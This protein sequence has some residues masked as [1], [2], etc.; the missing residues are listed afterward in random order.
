MP[1]NAIYRA[2]RCVTIQGS[3]AQHGHLQDLD[4]I[5]GALAV[6]IMLYHYGLN[7][8][9]N[10]LS[11]NFF[12]HVLWGFCVDFFFVL[13]GFVL[14]MSLTA[15]PM[16][17]SAFAAKRIR[18]L[19]PV[20]LAILIAFFPALF[21]H[22]RPDVWEVIVNLTLLQSS[23]GM[24]SINQPSWSAGLELTLPLLAV[25][26][27][28]LYGRLP[29]SAALWALLACSALAGY[30][31][32]LVAAGPTHEIPRAILGLAMGFL[33][34]PV[35]RSY[36]DPK[37]D[38]RRSLLTYAS[39]LAGIGVIFVADIVP[40]AAA[41]FPF[42]CILTIITGS[43]SKS[44]LST[45]VAQWFGSRSYTIY[46]VHFPVLI[47]A[48][49]LFGEAELQGNIAL[50]AGMIALSLLLADLLT[51]FVELPMMRARRREP[52]ATAP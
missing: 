43:R 23:V 2:G 44:L 11:D 21:V 39:L 30:V 50:K 17:L 47:A 42:A 32:A 25:A 6:C 52:A 40:A 38:T 48:V 8:V 33:L 45:P 7:S 29:K 35:A 31:L 26:A 5:R 12:D 24:R 49:E 18:R 36:I 9:I 16:K 34:F 13:S 1:I 3:K 15:R 41:L 19:L 22:Y 46:M 28:G 20:H 4:G 27:W 14:A 51:R 10:R 37:A